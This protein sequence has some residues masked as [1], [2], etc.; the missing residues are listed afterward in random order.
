MPVFVAPRKTQ[1]RAQHDT[2]DFYHGK[3]SG[4]WSGFVRPKRFRKEWSVRIF[5]HFWR[6]NGCCPAILM[7]VRAARFMVSGFIPFSFRV[8]LLMRNEL[9]STTRLSLR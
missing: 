2:E 8:A 7:S 1:E 5:N 9:R 4:L 3:R 6:P